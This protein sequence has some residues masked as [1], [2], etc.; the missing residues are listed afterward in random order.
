MMISPMAMG[1]LVVPLWKRLTKAAEPG[2]KCA[3][4]TPTAMAR[5]IQR[6][7]KRSRKESL[8]RAVGAQTRPCVRAVVD[9]SKPRRIFL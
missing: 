1:I 3:A 4:A 5:K 7:R 6:V 2:T 8:L 9:I